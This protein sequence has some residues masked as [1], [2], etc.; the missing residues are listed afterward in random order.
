MQ[1]QKKIRLK[2]LF[3]LRKGIGI[4][5]YQVIYW[6]AIGKMKKNLI[7]KLETEQGGVVEGFIGL[8]RW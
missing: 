6:V 8:R 1:S 4:P 2:N 7:S 3:V 5:N